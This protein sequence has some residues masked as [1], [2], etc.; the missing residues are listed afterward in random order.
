MAEQN[1]QDYNERKSKHKHARP[2]GKKKVLVVFIALLGL[3]YAGMAVYYTDHYYMGTRINGY[4]CSNKRANE[5]KNM[6]TRAVANYEM[7]IKERYY[8][9]E[10]RSGSEM[11][12]SFKDDGTLQ[13][14]MRAQ[15]PLLWI[16]ALFKEYDYGDG[17]VAVSLNEARF[18]DTFE[19]LD[20]LNDKYY[21]KTRDAYSK[22][23]SETGKYD[24]IK[25]VNGNGLEKNK[26]YEYMKRAALKLTPEINIGETS[27]YRQPKY[28]EDSDKIIKSNKNLNK[29]ASTKVT[30]DFDD[31]KYVVDGNVVNKWLS[32]DKKFKVHLD[33]DKVRE[34]VNNMADETDTLG[35][36]RT[37]KSISGN[38]VTVSGGTYGWQMDRETECEHLISAIKKAKQE[39]RTPEYFQKGKSR[40]TNDLG[41][42]YVEVD[43][44]SQH[45]WFYKDGKTLVSTD[46]VTGCVSKGRSTPQGTYYILYKQTNHTMVGP[47][48]RSFVNYW[49]P[50]M[51]RGIG[52][53]DSSWRGSY[54]GSIYMYSGSHG[55]VNMPY[56]AVKAVFY[57]IDPGYPVCVHY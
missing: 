6:L 55:C 18:R 57:N 54:G 30:Y 5:V 16:T 27:A 12:L 52:L 47:G 38:H 48:Y 53:H 43:L 9:E 41:D 33:K 1:P 36:T 4:D 42:T 10:K 15:N 50:F 40:K 39:K 8:V 19:G 17:Q 46:V 14:V 31:R 28:F 7:T 45:L 11:G 49:M 22:Y 32:L 23:N 34:Y 24:I 13:K 25:E 2:F 37:F 26:F 29:Y 44:G 21:I 20:A 35:A 56:S 51:D 3:F